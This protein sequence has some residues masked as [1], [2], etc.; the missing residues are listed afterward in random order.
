MSPNSQQHANNYQAWLEAMLVVARHYRVECSEEQ[1]KGEITWRQ[2]LSGEALLA[3]IARRI[4]LDSRFLA[5]DPSLLDPVHLPLVVEF[6]A[7]Q[8]G[9]VV[10]LDGAGQAK[11][12]LSGEG[13][14]ASLFS[15][16]ELAREARKIGIFRPL[17]S[18]SDSRVDEYIKPVKANWLWD[19][20][21]QDWK[22]HV[23]IAL[24]SMGA[25]VLALAGTIFSMQVYDRVIPAQ[26]EPSLWVL[27]GG[28]LLAI[29]FEFIFRLM[30]AHISDY[31]GK[32]ADLRISDMVFGR[33]LRIKN[34]ERPKSTGSFIAQIRELEQIR[35]MVASTTVG[36]LADIPF[37]IFFVGIVWLIG[38]ELVWVPLAAM[39]LLVIPGLLVQKPL[40]EFSREGLRES[41]IRN[42]ILVESVQNIEDIKLLRAEP[43]VL[44]QWNHV[45]EVA[46]TL[47]VKQRFLTNMLL[48]WIQEVQALVYATILLVGAYLVMDGKITTGSLVGVSILSSR[49][50]APLAMLSGV[51]ARWQQAKVAKEGLDQL[52]QKGVDQP[53]GER[54]VHRPNLLGH[55][56]LNQVAYTYGET[57]S[58]PVLQQLSLEIQ[59]G[60]RVAILGRNGSGKSTLL[61]VLS[62]MRVPQKGELMLDGIALH[63]LDTADVRRDVAYLTQSPMLF[64]GTLRENI[65]LGKPLASDQEIFEALR[66]SGAIDFVQGLPGGLDYVI[67]EGGYGLSGGQRQAIL[68]ARTLITQPNI[69]LLDEP[70]TWLDD[71][72][73]KALVEKLSAWV[74]GRTLVVATHRLALLHLVERIVVI[75]NGRVVLD[76]PKERVLAQLSGQT[77]PDQGA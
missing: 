26:S 72:S 40:A 21:R 5:G 45:N 55:Y 59:A 9:V 75:D 7:G 66:L 43:R 77:T 1:A 23:D 71:T 68:L 12:L 52:M 15:P 37:F 57:N 18:L 32:R 35:E 17:R 49:M 76:G 2:G 51:F 46:A 16:A 27:F 10:A 60:E 31:V 13:G 54:R 11:V 4:G 73:E 56:T 62:G 70:T 24:A 74:P 69:L 53:E 63:L 19:I 39:L 38:G 33:A 8:V 50:L 42:A 65:A 67:Q 41:S 48:G 30:R 22:R 6:A 20:L 28:V 64:F 34:D 47:G 3:R 44:A 58:K 29:V 25:N 36:V 61:N 14:I